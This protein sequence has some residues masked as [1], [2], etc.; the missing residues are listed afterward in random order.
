MSGTDAASDDDE[1][2]ALE[3]SAADRDEVLALLEDGIREA[4]RKVTSGRV[5]DA[6]NE[7]VRQGW[8]RV[9]AYSANQYRQ[10]KADKDLEQMREDLEALEREVRD[11][12]DAGDGGRA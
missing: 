6:E 12:H 11:D 9:L 3:P 1:T 10:L 2:V 4:H 7:K 5:R 8:I